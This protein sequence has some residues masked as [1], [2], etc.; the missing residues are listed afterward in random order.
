[1]CS[2]AFVDHLGEALLDQVRAPAP[3]AD[4]LLDVL[5]R[6]QLGAGAARPVARL[7]DELGDL[8]EA[9]RE[10]ALVGGAARA[11]LDHARDG[12]GV[13]VAQP[14]AGDLGAD[15]RRVARGSCSSHGICTSKSARTRNSSAHVL[16][17]RVHQLVQLARARRGRP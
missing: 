12:A 13:E 1:M 8:L 5:G 7:G 2:G 11:V 4:R 15:E 6:H 10:L 9:S 17:E 14:V 16:V 3:L